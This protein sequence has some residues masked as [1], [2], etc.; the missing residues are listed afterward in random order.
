MRRLEY[1]ER[2]GNLHC[3]LY[4]IEPF[5]EPCVAVQMVGKPTDIQWFFGGMDQHNCL[6]ISNTDNS[7]Y[8]VNISELGIGWNNLEWLKQILRLTAAHVALN[9]DQP[10]NPTCFRIPCHVLRTKLK[11][12]LSRLGLFYD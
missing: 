12:Y 2:I 11:P 10:F 3:M 7:Y 4:G 1:E 8:G 6:E 9:T 5:D